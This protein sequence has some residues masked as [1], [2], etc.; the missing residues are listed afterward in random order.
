M[1]RRLAIVLATMALMMVGTV[2][3]AFAD[4]L[5]P[6]NDGAT[7]GTV[8]IAGQSGKNYAAHHIAFLAKSGSLG[9]GGHKPGSHEGFTL[10]D[11]SVRGLY[12]CLDFGVG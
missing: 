6:C 1:K 5:G 9:N 4:N 12:V 8:P 3:A 11:P 7:G 10:C 2:P